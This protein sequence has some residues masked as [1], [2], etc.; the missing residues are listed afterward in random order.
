MNR[1]ITVQEMRRLESDVQQRWRM[2]NPELAR[3][4]SAIGRITRG[5]SARSAGRTSCHCPVCG[6][7]G[8]PIRGLCI[9]CG[10]RV[11]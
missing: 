3:M 4:R 6:W 1:T 8:Y 2:K 11:H 10:R 5:T 7:T 9:V